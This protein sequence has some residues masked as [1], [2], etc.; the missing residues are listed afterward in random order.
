MLTG[1]T[2]SSRI[3]IQFSYRG[4]LNSSLDEVQVIGRWKYRT[5]RGFP[6][7]KNRENI[8]EFTFCIRKIKSRN[9]SECIILSSGAAGGQEVMKLASSLE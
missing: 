1:N 6:S 8:E 7:L 5:R 3:A 9:D 4:V 2:E